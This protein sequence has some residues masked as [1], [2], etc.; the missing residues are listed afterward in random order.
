LTRWGMVIDLRKC[1]GCGACVVACAEA[2][3]ISPNLWRRVF[4]CG[5]SRPPKRQRLYLPINCMHC[6]EPPCKKVCPTTATFQR[7]DGI[8]DIDFKKCI[9]C[10]YCIVACPYYARTI[11][12]LNEYNIESLVMGG[13]NE[14][15]ASIPDYLGVCTKCNFCKARLDAGI[16]RGLK[17]GKDPEASPVCVVQCTA[18]AIYFG[19]LNDSQS[20]VARLVRENI[21]FCFQENLGTQPRIYYIVNTD[22]IE[23]S[24]F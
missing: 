10:G 23:E 19:D 1:F 8:V 12:F 18:E 15:R 13:G 11:I 2:N 16:E 21:T 4:D 24:S 3:K 17:P 6:D 9:G 20:Q 7:S 5:L 22:L 14:S